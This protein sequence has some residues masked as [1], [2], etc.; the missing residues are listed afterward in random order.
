MANFVEV[1]R[2]INADPLTLYSMVSDV[3]RMGEWSPETKRAEWLKG[4]TGPAVGAHFRGVN[5]LGSKKWAI[6]CV[7][8]KAEPGRE[9][10]F[11]ATAGPIKFAT[12][13]YSF[14]VQDGGTLVTESCDDRRGLLLTWVGAL[15]SG[16]KDR[17]ARNKVNISETL[18]ALKAAAERTVPADGPSQHGD[19]A[20]TSQDDA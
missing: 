17:E 15:I 18:D 11:N 19:D 1:S 5:K 8:T 10:A 7:V 6:E 3:T 20:A 12:W 13:S 4:A 14:E 9:F 2:V 16:V